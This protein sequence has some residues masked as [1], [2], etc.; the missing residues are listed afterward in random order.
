MIYLMARGEVKISEEQI[1]KDIQ[2]IINNE[3]PEE[4]EAMIGENREQLLVRIPKFVRE[5]LAIKKGDKLLFR[6]VTRDKKPFLEVEI[7]KNESP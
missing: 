7:R 6:V 3:Y 2:S 1:K 5:R 4:G